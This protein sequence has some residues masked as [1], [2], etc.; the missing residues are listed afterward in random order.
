MK[1]LPAVLLCCWGFGVAQAAP[2]ISL[3]A[4]RTRYDAVEPGSVGG[5]FNRESGSLDRRAIGLAQS[6]GAWRL[7]G[8]FSRASGSVDY[9]GQTQFALPLVTTSG[10]VRED[11]ALSVQRLWPAFGER[12]TL[13]LGAGA[14]A[15]R[16]ARD[17]RATPF[18]SEL[19][20]TLRARQWL[21]EAGAS[22]NGALLDRPL[23]FSF[24]A[25]SS[26]PWRQTLAV[27]AHGLFDPLEL[28]PQPRWSWQFGL[29]AQ[30]QMA[31]AWA[32]GLQAGW[33][34]YRPGVGD[35]RAALRNGVPVGSASYPGS[36]QR[37]RSLDLV[38]NWREP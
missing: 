22:T 13:S 17:I 2:E 18:S 38:L 15:L 32:L 24:T 23:R 33:D 7:G 37:M 19:S 25:R 36:D 20:E 3:S 21:L 12:M 1:P 16:S 29:A 11:L 27:D 30:W 9:A 6:F 4:G 35:S 31:P 8:Q 5:P 28:E 34:R 14:S 10:V 26:R